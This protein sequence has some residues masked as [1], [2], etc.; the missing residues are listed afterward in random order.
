MLKTSLDVGGDYAMRIRGEAHVWTADTV[1]N[2]QHAVRGNS[3][4]IYRAFAKHVNQQ[5]ERLKTM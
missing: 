5:S 2:L 3:V 4:A 1:S